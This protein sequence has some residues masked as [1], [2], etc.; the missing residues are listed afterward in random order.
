MPIPPPLLYGQCIARIQDLLQDGYDE[1]CSNAAINFVGYCDG[2]RQK[3]LDATIRK[4]EYLE[5]ELLLLR[6]RRERLKQSP[7]E[8][9]D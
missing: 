7:N 8:T 2:H 1:R 3:F 9:T 6:Q 4:I 5:A